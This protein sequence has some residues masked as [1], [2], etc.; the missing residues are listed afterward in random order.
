MDDIISA[1][2]PWLSL[3]A[4]FVITGTL[5]QS[6]NMASG[7]R[8]GAKNFPGVWYVWRRAFLLPIGALL[9]LGGWAIGVPA[10][11]AFGTEVGGGVLQGLLGAGA[12]ALLYDIFV[13]SVRAWLAHKLAKNG[14]E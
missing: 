11:E 9:G 8:A 7:A 2:S 1:V 10:N 3:I 13:G 5:M 12:A 14:N 6:V 4:Y